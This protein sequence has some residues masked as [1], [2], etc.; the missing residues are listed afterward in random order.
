MMAIQKSRR[1]ISNR[2]HKLAVALEKFE[3]QT[4]MSGFGL[5]SICSFGPA[6]KPSVPAASVTV[7]TTTT[8]ITKTTPTVNPNLG[9]TLKLCPS[10]NFNGGTI[11]FSQAP[12]NVQ[13]GFNTIAT[14][15]S[16]TA[17]TAGQTVFLGNANGVESYSMVLTGPGIVSRVTVGL[18]GNPIIA[19]TKTTT[20][21]TTFSTANPG[22]AA[23]ITALAADL[24]LT[25]PSSTT[26]VCVVTD[27]SG[28]TYS[29][30]LKSQQV[31]GLVPL[32]QLHQHH[33]RQQG[34]P[35]R[36]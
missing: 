22:A 28:T 33:R 9:V 21:W 29:V 3:S 31:Q 32:R 6:T 17:P 23:G 19:P 10:F 27:A 11:L 7:P 16:L 34:Q 20:D 2:H 5:T 14:N 24:N 15:Q 35:G 4:L 18:D 25:A 13:A 26:T 30:N 12:A 1:S 36:R 8:T